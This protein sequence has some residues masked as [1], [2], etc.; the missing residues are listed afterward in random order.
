MGSC[1]ARAGPRA[2]CR[3]VVGMPAVHQ[4]VIAAVERRE[5]DRVPTMDVMVEYA[6]I[7]EI[8][9]RRPVPL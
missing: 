5:P 4:R 3:E 9:G 8:L 2:T 1:S 7:V 6:N